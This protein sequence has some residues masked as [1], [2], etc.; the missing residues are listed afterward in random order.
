MTRKKRE[1]A[2]SKP[3]KTT[4]PRAEGSREKLAEDFIAHLYCSWEQHGREALD[5]VFRE[6]PDVYFKAL[7]N[8]TVALHRALDK[9]RDFDRHRSREEALQRLQAA[10]E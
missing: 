4:C 5:R 7:V 10:Q 6:R 9:P 8:L 3:S 1:R 2:P